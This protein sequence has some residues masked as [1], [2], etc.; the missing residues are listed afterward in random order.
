MEEKTTSLNSIKEAKEEKKI[1]E[2]IKNETLKDVE[3]VNEPVKY[4]RVDS[5]EGYLEDEVEIV[6]YRTTQTYDVIFNSMFGD[7][8]ETGEYV[9]DKSILQALVLCH[10]HI[11]RAYADT[12]YLQSYMQFEEKG[13]LE[14]SI[15]F[16]KNSDGK[17]VAVLKILEPV[18]KIG[19]YLINTHSF[20]VATYTDVNDENYMLKVKKA[21]HVYDSEEE[22][23]KDD[24]KELDAIIKRL[25]L[26]KQMK[27][28]VLKEL[29]IR[30]EEYFNARLEVLK[31]VDFE[32][33]IQ[34]F[35]RLKD[36]AKMFINPNSP[37]Y[38]FYMN[39]L[40]DMAL[41]N[42]K[43]S[44]REL[45]VAVMANMREIM[46]EHSKKANEVFEKINALINEQGK[47]VGAMTK[48]K[49]EK[50]AKDVYE[51]YNAKGKAK[52]SSGKAL[53]GGTLLQSYSSKQQS[54]TINKNTTAKNEQVENDSQ[55]KGCTFKGNANEVEYN[56]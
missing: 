13:Y 5:I 1:E 20:V 46:L 38:Y 27:E 26:L 9:I 37:L 12:L 7:Y 8:D 31:N 15:S 22:G 50:G 43:F 33:V 42:I 28:G 44:N 39:Q 55:L 24:L 23:G 41:Y 34:E 49:A 18:S 4:K 21:F 47:T 11:T 32:P 51:H 17:T 56:R 54:S 16:I 3:P 48:K 6:D 52:F 30:E 2:Q 19:G 29:N 36:K 25:N 10:K 14:F 45:S 53:S 35:E 40:L